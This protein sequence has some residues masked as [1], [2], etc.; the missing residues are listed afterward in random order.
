MKPTTSLDGWPKRLNI[1]ASEALQGNAAKTPE[2]F[3]NINALIVDNGVAKLAARKVSVT[4]SA[5]LE[6]TPIPIPSI[7]QAATAIDNALPDGTFQS[8]AG[9]QRDYMP[10]WNAHVTVRKY[11]VRL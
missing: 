9:Q 4:G 6:E 8:K 10:T 7:V 3:A 11:V 2:T 5:I 1:E